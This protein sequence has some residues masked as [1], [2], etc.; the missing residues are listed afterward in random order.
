MI[1]AASLTVSTEQ[2]CFVPLSVCCPTAYKALAVLARS[3]TVAQ[4]R[5]SHYNALHV[6]ATYTIVLSDADTLSRVCGTNDS[7]IKLIEGHLGVPVF[8]RGNELSIETADEAKRQE[9]RFII[10]RITDELAEGGDGSAGMVASI[11]NTGLASSFSAADAAISVPGALRKIF[12]KT[13]NQAALIQALRTH[14][15]VFATGPAGSGKTFLAVAEALRLLL[16]H[17]V[18]GIVLTRPVVEAGESLGFLPGALEDKLSPYLR[19]LYDSMHAVL[20]RE[21]VHKLTETG[22]IEVAP[23][24]YMRGRTMNNCAIILDEAQN[25]TREQMKMFL[26]RMGEGSKMFVTGDLTQVDLPRKSPSGLVHA[27]SLLRGIDGIGIVE[28]TGADV[29]RRALVKKIVQAYEHDEDNE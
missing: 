28:L 26:T 21:S 11:L 17:K 9:F 2:N 16:S 24:A 3:A 1:F 18:N 25:T 22:T 12:P 27:L 23:L 20:P 4:A 13:K 15:L 29:V 5:F 10:D 14:D 6:D 19:P 8:T 7:N